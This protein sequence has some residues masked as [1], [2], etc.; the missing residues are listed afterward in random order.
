M[1]A[2]LSSLSSA[3]KGIILRAAIML[4]PA[5]AETLNDTFESR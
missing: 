1:V 2:Q 5:S 3:S 4:F